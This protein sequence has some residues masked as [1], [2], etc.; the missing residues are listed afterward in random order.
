LEHDGRIGAN[1]HA[2][3]VP[4]Q[5]PI[6]RAAGARARTTTRAIDAQC[7][8]LQ[9]IR[10]PGS[11]P[12]VIGQAEEFGHS[13]TQAV[14]VR[15]LRGLCSAARRSRIANCRTASDRLSSPSAN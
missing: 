1:S 10:I 6:A 4:V 11:G 5:R 14:L 3:T 9:S 7:I 15:S 12:I 2:L 13:G 8:D